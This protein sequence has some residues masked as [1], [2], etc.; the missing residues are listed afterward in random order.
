VHH[1]RKALGG[2]GR[3]RGGP[4]LLAAHAPFDELSPDVLD[5][6]PLRLTVRYVR[7]GT[8]ILSVGD[9]NDVMYVLR[10][11]AVDIADAE[12]NLVER[13]DPGTSFAMSTLLTG[14]P[15]RYDFTAIED[16]LLLVMPGAE[17]DGLRRTSPVFAEFY[18]Q[19]HVSRLRRAVG[20]LQVS[21]RGEAVLKTVTSNLVRRPPVT[22]RLVGI[23][24]DRDLRTRVLAA[25]RDPNDPVSSVM[26]TEPATARATALAFEVL[27]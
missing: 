25:N 4:R 9:H 15:S 20:S 10:S 16:S 22:D 5:A 17:F 26:T 12:G 8:R 6:L 18:S 13:S 24:T 21:G 3:T 1:A 27:C 19:A 7:R 23:L 2:G 11:G 14:Q